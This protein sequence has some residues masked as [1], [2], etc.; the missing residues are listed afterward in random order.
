[1]LKYVVRDYFKAFNRK[2]VKTHFREFYARMFVVACSYATCFGLQD[3]DT[4]RSTRI[5]LF[6]ITFSTIFIYFSG[7]IHTNRLPKMMYLCPMSVKERKEYIHK[8]FCFKIAFDLLIATGA[9]ALM[10]RF[11]HFD[12][13]AFSAIWW[14]ELIFSVLL[15]TTVSIDDRSGTPSRNNTRY[16]L[17]KSFLEF[18]ILISVYA[19]TCTL[20]IEEPAIVVECIG[21]GIM[22]C[23]ELPM[24]VRF[25]KYVRLDLRA[26]VEFEKSDGK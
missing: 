13:F 11:S 9:V 5:V 4:T 8:S 25:L 23:L 24:I 12:G 22:L 26:A 1:M 21:F 7:C 20:M 18:I 3:D 2:N 6:A 17:L 16:G 14:N 15:S 19:W 10:L